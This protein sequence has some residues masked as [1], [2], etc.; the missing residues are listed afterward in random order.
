MAE[1]AV[2]DR[3][4]QKFYCHFCNIQFENASAVSSRQFNKIQLNEVQQVHR[5]CICRILLVLIALV[6]S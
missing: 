4:H 1:A 5:Y 3:P 6:D 2:E